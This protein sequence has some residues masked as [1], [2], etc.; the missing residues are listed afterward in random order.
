MLNYRP[1]F[2]NMNL[3][4]NQHLHSTGTERSHGKIYSERLHNI[5]MHICSTIHGNNNDQNTSS[6]F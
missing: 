2:R 3:E 5:N 1:C 4:A 6:V